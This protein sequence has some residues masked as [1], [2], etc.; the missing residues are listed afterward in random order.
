M[1]ILALGDIHGHDKWQEIIEN[2]TYDKVVFI[3]D[4]FDSFSVP[5]IDQVDNF[6][7]ILEFKRSNPDNVILLCGNHD[8]HYTGLSRSQCSGYKHSLHVNMEIALNKCI[9]NDEIVACYVHDNFIFT[10]AGLSKTWCLENN[11][12][13]SITKVEEELNSLFKNKKGAFDFVHSGDYY[14]NSIHQ[15]PFWIRPE[16]LHQDKIDGI[17]IVGHTNNYKIKFVDNEYYVI[18]S[19]PYQYLVIDNGEVIIKDC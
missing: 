2:E 6:Y 18:D 11:I 4:Y 1:K 8:Y 7:K 15:G 13:S 10:H 17:H 9:D 14:G 16:S 5:V 3:G 12:N 19:L